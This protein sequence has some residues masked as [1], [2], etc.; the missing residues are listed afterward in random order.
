[1]R[2]AFVVGLLVV[3]FWFFPQIAE[4]VSNPCGALAIRVA[5][6]AGR[7]NPDIGTPLAHGLVQFAGGAVATEAMRQRYP[8]TPPQ[9]SCAF[10]YWRVTFRPD[11]A[12]LIGPR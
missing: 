4:G 8:S 12:G 9:L 6:L 5:T 10:F 3:G 11:D 1:M 2:T 7:G